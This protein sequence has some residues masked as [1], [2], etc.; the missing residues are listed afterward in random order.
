[1]VAEVGRG[2]ASARAALAGNPSDGYGGAV[3][4]VTLPG[5][6]AQASARFAAQPDISP[7]SQ[8]VRAA[9]LRFA[10]RHAR[11]AAR[12]AIDWSTSIPR[13]VGLGG[14]SA[15]VIAVLRAL[16]GLHRVTL[17]RTELAELALAVEVEELGIAAGLQDRVAQAYGG[18]TFM[19]FAAGSTGYETLD[20]ALLPPLL[21][22]W[23][24]DAGGASDEVHAPLRARYE[25]GET[26][27]LSGLRE[28]ASLARQARAALV[29]GDFPGVLRC[30][31][32]TFD[33]RQRMLTLDA[34]HVEMVRCA[35]DC[36]A[37]ANYAGS[38]GAIVAVCQNG[39]QLRGA[40]SEL[41]R[42]DC[43]TF[44]LAPGPV[45]GS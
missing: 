26:A 16:C 5:Y 34:R 21:V 11:E 10:S 9:T 31:D 2:A 32:G 30:V 41:A 28:L 19:D 20:S 27:V 4:A 43:K 44:A 18:L 15:I 1:M 38:G 36:G 37:A 6:E 7:P 33:Q 3:L 35:R 45:T 40:A 17:T 24:A 14:S 13:G 8:L 29:A 42:L 23:R 39:D 22:A 25:R 12:S